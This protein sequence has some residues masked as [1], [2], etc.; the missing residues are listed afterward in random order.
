MISVII[1][2]YN[3]ENYVSKAV[4][5]A[6]GQEEVSEVI[7]VDDGS[8]DQSLNICQAIA[9]TASRVK[10]FTHND[11]VNL[12]RSH[13]RNLGI[14]KANGKYIGFL[15]ADDFYLPNRFTKDVA[16]LESD[17]GIDGV[18]NAIGVHFYRAY[19][20]KESKKLKLTTIREKIS[21][22]NLFE[23]MG[24]I[25]H[26]GYFSGI[27]LTVRKNIFDKVGLFNENLVVA[28][29]TELWLKMSL[30]ANLVGGVLHKPVSMRG[31]HFSNVSFKKE[32]LY[33]R[34]FLKMYMSLYQWSKRNELSLNRL[35]IIWEKI[36]FYRRSNNTQLSSDVF[37]WIKEMLK[38]P[39]MLLFNNNYK[40]F[41]FFWRLKSHLN[42]NIK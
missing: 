15:D 41:P 21:G 11:R 5:S 28:E 7:V 42:I 23:L 17:N 29:D 12:G 31:V 19:T 2:V 20:E 27:G 39:K 35:S 6:L 1:P 34:N 30:K 33:N 10:I 38:T 26:M 9:K 22:K 3:A 18:Y 32:D 14:K 13:T 40:T 16:M 4:M 36:W 8:S 25:G 24:P 37:Y